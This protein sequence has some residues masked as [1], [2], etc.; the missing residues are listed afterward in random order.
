M[1]F[2]ARWTAATQLLYRVVAGVFISG[3]SS[4]AEQ[5]PS[6][7]SVALEYQAADGCPDSAFF[8]REV[9]ARTL[10]VAFTQGREVSRSFKV[11]VRSTPGSYSGFL[12]I[13]DAR[14]AVSERRFEA[15]KCEDVIVAL[16]LVAALA[17][18]PN[19]SAAPGVSAKAE[20]A[21]PAKRS[22]VREPA[23][24]LAPAPVAPAAPTFDRRPQ[25]APARARIWS[26]GPAF[27]VLTATTTAPLLSIGWSVEVEEKRS[28]LAPGARL[29]P[30]FAETGTTGPSGDS[31]EFRLIAAR[32]E[33]CALALALSRGV[34]VRPC[35][36]VD[37]GLLQARGVGADLPRSNEAF[38]LS[39]VLDLRL[40]LTVTNRF[41]VEVAGGP[42]IP[43]TRPEFVFERP[44]VSVHEVPWL[45]AHAG[46]AAAGTQ[47]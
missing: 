41:F 26:S 39:L 23:P 34:R 40:Q 1:L 9:R 29:M 8:A 17:V 43:V 7:H 19:A 42:V 11:A 38:W 25:S 24:R 44:L 30:F 4:G 32:L 35:L 20:E 21:T 18:D 36:G 16:A 10:Q 12:W 28:G 13:A 22:E 27:G 6:P 5:A 31:A 15:A 37:T 14:G 3:A 33:G 46:L 45:A 2:R 47:F